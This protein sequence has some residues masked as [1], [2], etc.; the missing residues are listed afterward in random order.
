M[1]RHGLVPFGASS[2]RDTGFPV[3]RSLIAMGATSKTMDPQP[4]IQSH[5]SCII[6]TNETWS[7][8]SSKQLV[9]ILKRSNTAIIPST[10]LV[11]IKY[12]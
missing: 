4:T 3:N 5:F 6:M 11:A 12:G 9:M 8:V 1:E 2:G 10:E 7:G